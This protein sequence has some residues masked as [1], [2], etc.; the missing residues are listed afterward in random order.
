MVWHWGRRRLRQRWP[1]NV[2]LALKRK[3]DNGGEIQNLADVSSG[4]MLRLKIVKS[5][6]EE[7]AVSAAA[8]DDD[9]T[10]NKGGKGTQ[11]LL[12]LTEPWHHSDRLVT[13]DAYFA[14]VEAALKLKEKDLFSLGTS[15]S[16]AGGSQW[17]FLGT[18]PFQSEDR[19]W[20]LH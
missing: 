15:S 10:A 7:K 19:N 3:P 8:A 18:S 2:S 20:F 13:G 12:E 14:S 5:T 9:I 6:A 1:P 17:R 16:A 4:I 11:V